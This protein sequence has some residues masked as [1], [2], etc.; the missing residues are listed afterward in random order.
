[1]KN[2]ILCMLFTFSEIMLIAQKDFSSKK[3]DQEVK[4]AQSS[5]DT[6]ITKTQQLDPFL[7]SMLKAHQAGLDQQAKKFDSANKAFNP[8]KSYDEIHYKEELKKEQKQNFGWF[9]WVLVVAGASIL[10]LVYNGYRKKRD[11]V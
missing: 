2:V 5:G 3:T 8:M 6:I 1:M 4:T 9:K 7:D 10:V 11:N